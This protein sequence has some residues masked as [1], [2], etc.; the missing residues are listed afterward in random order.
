MNDLTLFI[1]ITAF[2][3]SSLFAFIL[4]VI[5]FHYASMILVLF[6]MFYFVYLTIRN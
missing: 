6:N 4:A 1:N 3:L 5:G 2:I